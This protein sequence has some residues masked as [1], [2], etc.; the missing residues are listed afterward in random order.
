[1]AK[2]KGPRISV[3][4]LAEYIGSKGR[5]QREILRDQKFPEDFKGMYYREA[6]EAV[7]RC[8]ASDLEDTAV[9]GQ[10]R[11]YSAHQLQYRRAGI[12]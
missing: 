3:N 6:S 5:R 12:V 4:K 2:D 10:N 7:S 1:M 11:H 8:L 9:I